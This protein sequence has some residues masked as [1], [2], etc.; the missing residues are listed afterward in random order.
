MSP[1]QRPPINPHLDKAGLFG[2]FCSAA[3]GMGCCGIPA[4]TAGLGALGLGFFG[5]SWFNEPA[6]YGGL[7]L[8]VGGLTISSL[9]SRRVAPLF[10][11]LFGAGAVLYGFR[12]VLDVPVFRGVVFGGLGAILM[13]SVWGTI[14]SRRCCSRPGRATLSR[15]LEVGSHGG[16]RL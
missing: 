4:L 9:T 3:F 7:A 10:L 14:Q 13:A 1:D 6:L 2:A 5:R 8:S 12:T 15:S 11:G 16:S